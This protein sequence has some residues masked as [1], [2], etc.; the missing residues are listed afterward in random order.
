MSIELHENCTVF[1]YGTLM[2]G[3]GNERV[4]SDFPHRNYPARIDNVEMYN[5]GGFPALLHGEHSYYGELVVFDPSVDRDALYRSMDRLEGYH[6][7]YPQG[8]M[9]IRE[10]VTVCC[11]GST[12]VTEVYIWNRSTSGLAYIDPQKY[13][14]YRDFCIDHGRY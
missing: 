11:E 1:V 4:I 13:S 7:D 3:F 8:S 14:N 10:P 6:S 2:Q 12:V 5:V 9:Y